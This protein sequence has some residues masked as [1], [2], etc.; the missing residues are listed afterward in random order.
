MLTVGEMMT[1]N[2]ITI[3]GD[4][5]VLAAARLMSERRIGAMLVVENH[6]CAGIFTERDVVRV[7]GSYSNVAEALGRLIRTAMTATPDVA[8]ADDTYITACRQMAQGGYRHLPVVDKNRT[9]VGILS[10]KDLLI[11][12]VFY[13]DEMVSDKLMPPPEEEG[14]SERLRVVHVAS[15]HDSR[16]S[17][18]LD[19]MKVEVLEVRDAA[20]ARKAMD[21]APTAMVVVDHDCRD[22]EIEKLLREV[23]LSAGR[24]HVHRVVELQENADSQ[25]PT[26]G[27]DFVGP[28]LT[29]GEVI[30][31]LRLGY[32]LGCVQYQRSA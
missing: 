10:V 29:S 13:F 19:T 8:R 7:L 25:A 2:L 9:P 3:S 32:R 6:R 23:G 18:C 16:I 22:N 11:S 5:T 28:S 14:G 17:K 27:D 31:H 24:K 1:T 20:S 30:A 4:E 15:S 12:Q 26:A 21:S